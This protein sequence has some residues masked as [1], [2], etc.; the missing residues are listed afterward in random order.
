VCLNELF[1]LSLSSYQSATNITYQWQYGFSLTGSYFDILGATGPTYTPPTGQ[2]IAT[3]YRCTITCTSSGGG[4]IK[5]ASVFVNMAPFYS[6]YCASAAIY[7]DDTKIDTVKIGTIVAGSL[8]DQCETYTD[9]TWMV[10]NV[11]IGDATP[12]TIRNG[13]CTGQFND[14]Y[15]AVYIDYNMDKDFSDANELVY[16]YADTTGINTIPIGII[17]VPSS[18]DS[19]ITGYALCSARLILFPDPVDCMTMAKPRIMLCT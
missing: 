13:S 3:Y 18:V 9:N 4:S 2:I 10:T 8:E 15:V 14:S 5:S 1:T 11:T 6:C 19:G 17:N 7:Q 12:I 16:S